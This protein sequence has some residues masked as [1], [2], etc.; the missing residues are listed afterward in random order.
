MRLSSIATPLASPFLRRTSTAS[1]SRAGSPAE[2][3]E[4][5]AALSSGPYS[6]HASGSA[7]PASGPCSATQDAY[8]YV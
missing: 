6:D 2:A 3:T 7:L 8:M 4:A 1:P 5:K